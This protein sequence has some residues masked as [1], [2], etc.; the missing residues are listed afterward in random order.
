[1]RHSRRAPASQEFVFHF[2]TLPF[3]EKKKTRARG[4]FA[5]WRPAARENVDGQRVISAPLVALHTMVESACRSLALMLRKSPIEWLLV[6]GIDDSIEYFG[7][8]AIIVMTI[9]AKAPVR[10]TIARS[11]ADRVAARRWNR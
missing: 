6:D 7:P 4:C 9:K 8:W 2:L 1:M 5:G 11:V 10:L 3:F